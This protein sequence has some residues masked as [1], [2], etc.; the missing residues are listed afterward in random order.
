MF[1]TIVVVCFVI[2]IVCFI[3]GKIFES[4]GNDGLG[5]F[6]GCIS[7]FTL[8]G[9]QISLLIALVLKGINSS[10]ISLNDLLPFIG[11]F[12]WTSIILGI[13]I[14]SFVCFNKLFHW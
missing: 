2:I 5:M 6:F 9:L 4:S 14:I 13:I 11:F 1:G 10:N 7:V 8:I 12:V 3:I